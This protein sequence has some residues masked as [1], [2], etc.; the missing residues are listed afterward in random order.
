M[1]GGGQRAFTAKSTQVSL[2]VCMSS[3]GRRMMASLWHIPGSF[4]CR[5]L[6]T[7]SG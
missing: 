6:A 1:V 3:P 2:D 4:P 5:G 7:F